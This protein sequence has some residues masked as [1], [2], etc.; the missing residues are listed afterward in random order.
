VGGG[1]SVAAQPQHSGCACVGGAVCHSQH[2]PG[3]QKL[4]MKGG[5]M[6]IEMKGGR[7]PRCCSPAREGED[8]CLPVGPPCLPGMP[9]LAQCRTVART[10]PAQP[11]IHVAPRIQQAHDGCVRQHRR[12]LQ[13]HTMQHRRHHAAH[14]P[15]PGRQ[16]AN[17]T[18]PWRSRRLAMTR[19]P[20]FTSSSTVMPVV[21]R[22]QPLFRDLSMASPAMAACGMGWG[23]ERW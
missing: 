16:A 3:H 6:P 9:A 14:H 21:F 20:R 19:A 5:R 11:H 15:A 10:V 22:S 17:A 8:V 1:G 2:S 18:Q 23:G 4:E 12:R 13:L 7:M